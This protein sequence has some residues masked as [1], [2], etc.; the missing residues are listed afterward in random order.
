M[1]HRMVIALLILLALAAWPGLAIYTA[2]VPPLTLANYA[3]FFAILFIALATTC[4]LTAYLIG[5][6]IVRSRLYQQSLLRHALR[7]GLLLA[8]FGVTNLALGILRAWSIVST[9]LILA[10][11]VLVEFL[12]L[13]RKSV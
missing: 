10:A 5:L 8:L 7:Q 2:G 1:A 6:R 4:A 13:A 12:S 11:L 9:L 3:S